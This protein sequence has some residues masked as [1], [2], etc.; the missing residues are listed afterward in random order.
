[1]RSVSVIIPSNREA[2][3]IRPCLDALASQ[4]F[5]GE[6][7][8]IVVY[9][10]VQP[11]AIQCALGDRLHVHSLAQTNIAAAK[12]VGLRRATGELILLLN[13]D[14]VPG[15]DLVAAHVACHRRLGRPAFVL[16]RSEWAP[17]ERPAVFDEMI[18]CTP[19]VFFYHG[20]AA[21]KWHS[22]RHAWNLNLSVSRDVLGHA[23]FAEALGPFFYEDVELAF[24]LECGAGVRVWYEPLATAQH[25]HRYTLEE[26]LRRETAMGEA[27]V[28]LARANAA[29]FKAIYGS[30]LDANYAAYCRAYVRHESAFAEERLAR[31]TLETGRAARELPRDEQE[32]QTRLMTLYDALLPLKRLEFRR[33]L[34]RALDRA[35]ALEPAGAAA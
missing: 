26:Y 29:C 21:D 20:L 4:Q 11:P 10:G 7:E 5:G 18:R 14:V 33:G 32:C 8:V 19:L 35:A 16:G 17:H 6:I 15:A 12:N 22:F 25:V 24:R 28:R 13:D 3:A 1:M 30:A 9:N 27:A 2:A 23:R 31:L 34:V